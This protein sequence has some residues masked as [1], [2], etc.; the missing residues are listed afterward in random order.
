M[1]TVRVNRHRTKLQLELVVDGDRVARV[2]RITIVTM[3]LKNL[4]IRRIKSISTLMIELSGKITSWSS[5]HSQ[6]K[7]RHIDDLVLMIGQINRL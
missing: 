6:A 7:H 5:R 3:N 2:K 4:L 1:V